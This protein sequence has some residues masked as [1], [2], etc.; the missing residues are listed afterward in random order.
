ME[1]TL[2]FYD[3]ITKYKNDLYFGDRSTPE[4]RVSALVVHSKFTGMISLL[5]PAAKAMG[6]TPEFLAQLID[7]DEVLKMSGATLIR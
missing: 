5:I 1:S 2:T 4:N 7:G 6:V 3:L